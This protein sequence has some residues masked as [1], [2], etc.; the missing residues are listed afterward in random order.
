MEA[1]SV[2]NAAGFT[3]TAD[4]GHR[5]AKVL[6]LPPGADWLCP[7]AVQFHGPS[8]PTSARLDWVPR[9]SARD[10]KG[11]LLNEIAPFLISK[12]RVLEYDVGADDS[13]NV[14]CDVRLAHA[15][16]LTAQEVAESI[17]ELQ[18]LGSAWDVGRETEVA[19]I[20]LAPAD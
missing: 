2:A 14:I 13:L 1:G 10:L 8:L 18:E 11:L 4:A 3:I 20:Y 16:S 12:G 6:A 5:Q 15:D 19:R 7:L 9:A 17:T